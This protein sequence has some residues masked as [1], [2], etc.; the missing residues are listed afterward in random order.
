MAMIFIN[1]FAQ[2]GEIHIAVNMKQ[3]ASIKAL[4]GFFFILIS[5]LTAAE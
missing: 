3:Q 5:H 1:L 4:V 2:C